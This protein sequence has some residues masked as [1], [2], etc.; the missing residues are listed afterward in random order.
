MKRITPVR[1]LWEASDWP[2]FRYDAAALLG[3]LGL[4]RRRQ[5]ELW[6]MARS[7]GLGDDADGQALVAAEEVLASSGI[8]GERLDPAGVR[9]SVARRL[10]LPTAGLPQPGPR[11]DGA[12]A[13]TLDAVTRFDAPLDADRLFAWHA[14]LFPTGYS[15]LRRIVVGDWRGPAPM[16]VV[17]G[18]GGHPDFTRRGHVSTGGLSIVTL[19]SRN[20]NGASNIVSSL[21]APE[22][23][24]D[25]ALVD[26]IV[27]EH[28]IADLRGL[29]REQRAGAITSIAHPDDRRTL[30]ST[31]PVAACSSAAAA[32]SS[33]ASS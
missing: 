5:G 21:T 25:G 6:A 8:E 11:E 32:C 24:T 1:Y 27:T 23:S 9:S 15:G 7:L 31:E 19:R 17:S 28:G 33:T 29:D 2:R 4:A 14:A 16:R 26:V 10:D 3:P 22:R 30:L 18:R 12:V 20:R 13:V